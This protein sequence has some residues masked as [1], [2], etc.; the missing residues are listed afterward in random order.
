M[1]NHYLMKL[2]SE[3]YLQFVW[4]AHR[5]WRLCLIMSEFQVISNMQGL[6]ESNNKTVYFKPSLTSRPGIARTCLTAFLKLSKIQLPKGKP[7]GLTWDQAAPSMG[8]GEKQGWEGESWETVAKDLAC[9][10]LCHLGEIGVTQHHLNPASPTSVSLTVRSSS[11][12][13]PLETA[14]LLPWQGMC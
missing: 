9:L 11:I 13:K 10:S 5:L 8:K 6:S 4:Q 7:S 14:G 1:S 2:V 3:S 12:N